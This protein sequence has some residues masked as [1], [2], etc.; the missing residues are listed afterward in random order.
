MLK[1]RGAL[2]GIDPT[3]MVSRA[4]S[5]IA[6]EGPA[7]EQDRWEEDAGVNG[8]TVAVV[9]AALV[10]GA[11]F[12]QE[13]ARGFALKLADGWNARIEDWI[14][15]PQGPLC[16]DDAVDGYYVRTSPVEVLLGQGSLL[17]QVPIKNLAVDAGLAAN[18]QVATDFLQLVR[19]GL[20]SPHDPAVLSTLKVVDQHLKVSTPYGPVWRR[21]NGDGYGEHVDGAPFDGVGCGRAWPLL[22][23]E[24]G[25]YA[26]AAGEDPTPYLESMAAM[27]SSLGLLPEQVWDAADIE[28]RGLRLGRPSGSAMPLLWAHAEFVKLCYSRAAGTPVDRPLRT[29]ARY[30][31]GRCEVAYDIW[32][33]SYRPRRLRAG[34]SLVLTLKAPAVVRWGVDGWRGPQDVDAVDTG[35]GVWSAELPLET[36]KS[37]QSVQFTFRWLESGA[38]E[39]ADYALDIVPA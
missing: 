30:S 28:A 33:A 10:E 11:D 2:D 22:T 8:F 7:S 9:I 13:P 32:G 6:R 21:Y 31:G 36:L 5:F 18:A 34:H 35:L 25:H 4:L 1:D 37:G 29:A 26:V 19:F 12:L 39:G 23:G 15:A 38:W 14:F 3:P 24:R 17:D 20:R 27:S 16:G